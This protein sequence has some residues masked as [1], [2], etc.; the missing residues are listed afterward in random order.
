MYVG[1]ANTESIVSHYTSNKKRY[2][3]GY[4]TDSIGVTVRDQQQASN[5]NSGMT[6]AATATTTATTTSTTPNTTEYKR[7]RNS[8]D[9]NLKTLLEFKKNLLE[10][11]R[12]SEQGI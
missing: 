2:I 9:S 1:M 5:G 7:G 11:Q 6:A 3:F 8:L 10:E 4:L 12:R